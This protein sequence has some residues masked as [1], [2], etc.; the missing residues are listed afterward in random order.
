MS[1]GFGENEE[2]SHVG[3]VI[4]CMEDLSIA[5]EGRINLLA[6]VWL[7]GTWAEIVINV[8]FY[9]TKSSKGNYMLAFNS[10]TLEPCDTWIWSSL[11]KIHVNR[12]EIHW[13]RGI[14]RSLRGFRHVCNYWSFLGGEGAH[15]SRLRQGA[16]TVFHNQQKLLL[17]RINNVA[18]Y[19]ITNESPISENICRDSIRALPDQYFI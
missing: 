9:I 12:R 13:E 8:V 19:S 7:N 16:E 15:W 3:D 2:Q 4:D 1:V 14:K 6:C 5:S 11:L 18:F 17:L 10:L